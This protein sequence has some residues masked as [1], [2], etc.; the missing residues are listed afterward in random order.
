MT[1]PIDKHNY[2]LAGVLCAA[3]ALIG[4]LVAKMWH[5]WWAI[6][7]III[8]GIIHL[9]QFLYWRRFLARKAS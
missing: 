2:A 3:V 6:L 8:P 1:T 7:G 9:F 5:D 4:Y